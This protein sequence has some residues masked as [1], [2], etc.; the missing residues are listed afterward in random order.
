M[1]NVRDHFSALVCSC[2]ITH[3]FQKYFFFQPS[4]IWVETMILKREIIVFLPCTHKKKTNKIK[5]FWIKE[6][7]SPVLQ[8]YCYCLQ[9]PTCTNNQVHSDMHVC[10]RE[11][12]QL[13]PLLYQSC[14]SLPQH[15]KAFL[16][17]PSQTQV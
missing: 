7:I 16:H 6:I 13:K 1:D 9:L 12:G 14:V 2:I 5:I 10:D 17:F 3:S 8:K 4:E 15:T 11:K